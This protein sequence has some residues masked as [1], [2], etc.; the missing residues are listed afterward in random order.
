MC[1]IIAMPNSGVARL[2][3]GIDTKAAMNEPA[4]KTV[5][6]FAATPWLPQAGEN[7]PP[8]VGIFAAQQ[9][10]GGDEQN[11]KAEAGEQDER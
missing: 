6:W 1:T 9:I 10:G 7:A 3:I 8:Q 11:Q 4:V 5:D 2:T